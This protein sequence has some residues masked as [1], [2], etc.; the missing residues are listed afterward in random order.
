MK[1][2][3]IPTA[4]PVRR[5]G[6]TNIAPARLQEEFIKSARTAMGQPDIGEAAQYMGKHVKITFNGEREPVVGRITEINSSSSGGSEAAYIILDH[7]K[8]NRYSLITIQSIELVE[9]TQSA[10]PFRDLR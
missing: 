1:K 9:S 7:D 8:K 5:S 4:Q 10:L 3:I 6:A 2:E